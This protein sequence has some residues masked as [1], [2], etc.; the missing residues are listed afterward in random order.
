[1]SVYYATVNLTLIQGKYLRKKKKYVSFNATTKIIKC[2]LF[3][4]NIVSSIFV[5]WPGNIIV[6]FYLLHK[7]LSNLYIIRGW[8]RQI[9]MLENGRF[10]HSMY[11]GIF[12]LNIPTLKNF[13]IYLYNQRPLVFI[14]KLPNFLRYFLYITIILRYFPTLIHK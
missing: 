10:Y 14:N 5:Q 2:Q 3:S 9:M 1:L 6:L 13:W 4:L 7:R 8:N 11:L 12:K